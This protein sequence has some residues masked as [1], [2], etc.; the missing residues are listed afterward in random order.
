MR[1]AVAV[2]GTR[3]SPLFDVA[4]TLALFDVERGTVARRAEAFLEATFPP[5]RAARLAE[6]G[7]DVLICGAISR[8]LEMLIVARGIE[9]VPWVVGDAEEALRAFL[10]GQLEKDARFAMPGC[11]GRR[12]ARAGW[13]GPPGVARPGRFGGE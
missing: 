6:T 13:C 1:I 9:V 8:P 5:L 3:V 12:R 7:C 4:R 2:N 10:S 11:C